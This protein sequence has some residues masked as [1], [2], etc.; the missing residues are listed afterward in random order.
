[1]KN[2]KFVALITDRIE[3]IRLSLRS[4]GEFDVNVVARK[5]FNGGGHKNAA[6]GKTTETL[7]ET[8]TKFESIL[9]QYKQLLN[10]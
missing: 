4:K 10:P 9:P 6:G 8:V 3:N 7:E 2:I 5:H 1:M